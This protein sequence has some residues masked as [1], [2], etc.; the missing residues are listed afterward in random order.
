MEENGALLTELGF[1]IEPYGERE[2]VVRGVPAE[3]NIADIAGAV[4]EICENLRNNRDVDPAAVRDEVLHTV[5][6]KA[7]IK[8]GDVI[9]KDEAIA[10]VMQMT[11]LEDPYHCAHG[12]PTFF[13]IARKDFEKNFRRIV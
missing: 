10:L 12:R 8:A 6:C 7:A 13:K 11:K 4:E 2:Y 9:S 5:A 3:M 1:E